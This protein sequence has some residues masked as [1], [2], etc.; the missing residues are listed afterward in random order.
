MIRGRNRSR[1]LAFAGWL[2]HHLMGALTVVLACA[3]VFFYIGAERLRAANTPSNPGLF[4]DGDVIEVL[5]AIDGDEVLVAKG[6]EARTVVRVLGIKAFSASA[7]D[8]LVSGYGQICV[9]H[10]RKSVVGKSA[11]LDVPPQRVGNQGRLLATVFVRGAEGSGETDL[12]LDLVRRGYALVYTRFDF[13]RMEAY[14]S[15]QNEAKANG[16]GLWADERIRSR[17]ESLL[18]IWREEKR[19]D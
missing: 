6:A 19:Y 15:A 10:L 8:P 13:A 11:R 5:K 14:L 18:R 17:A 4:A 16:V 12:G 9:T 2:W 3:S 1:A 7:S